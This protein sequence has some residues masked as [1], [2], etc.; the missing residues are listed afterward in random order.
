MDYELPEELRMLQET[1]RRFV[2]REL[3]PIERETMEGPKLKPEAQEMLEEKAKAV[4]LWLYDVP[5]EYGG[6]GLGLLARAVV[7][8]ELARTIALPSRNVNIFGPIVSPILYFL[9]DEQKQ[10][11]LY[12]VLEG[13]LRHCFA[14][15]EPDAGGDPGNMRTTAVRDGDDYI[16]NGTK[17]FITGAADADFAQVIAATDR[18]KGSRGGISAFL[19]DMDTP[20]VNLLRAQETMMHDRPWEIA[21]EDVR[22]PSENM[23]GGEGDGFKFAQNWISAGRIRHGA[24]GIGVIERCL[25]L[26]ASYAKQRSTFGSPLAERQSVQ[27]MLVDSYADLH[28]LKLMVYAAASKHDD[29]GDIRYDSYIVK[30]FGDTKS[31]EAADKCM[32]IHGGLGLTTDLPIEHMWRDQRSFIIT[33]GPTEILK[34]ALSRHVLRQY[35]D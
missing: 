16:I 34:M 15:T 31:F 19:V 26:G 1:V 24:R 21:F 29:G 28:M 25:E 18:E 27:W 2:D 17:R 14:Q 22:V 12:P 8:A 11:Y 13:K 4:G 3:I 33:E 10:R 20:G 30:Y 5:E 7:W 32:Q 23:I 35:G 6:Q 9:N